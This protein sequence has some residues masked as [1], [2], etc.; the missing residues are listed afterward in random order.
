MKTVFGPLVTWTF[1][2]ETPIPGWVSYPSALYVKARL[3]HRIPPAAL[4]HER[5]KGVKRNRANHDANKEGRFCI[6][7]T[8]DLEQ[9][10]SGVLNTS[11]RCARLA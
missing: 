6:G 8:T 1:P 11:L 4:A 2:S 10:L 7:I 5:H 3:A 9:P